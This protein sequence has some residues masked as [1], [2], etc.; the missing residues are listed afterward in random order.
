M[1]QV[2]TK[3]PLNGYPELSYA[4]WNDLAFFTTGLIARSID[5]RELHR[6][7]IKNRSNS[8]TLSSASPLVLLP[9]IEI[10]LSALLP[11]MTSNRDGFESD[12]SAS[13]DSGSHENLEHLSL[14]QHATGN[15]VSGVNKAWADDIVNISFKGI[16]CLAPVDIRNED[17]SQDTQL[18]CISEAVIRTRI[19]ARSALLSNLADGEV[20]Y[21]SRRGQFLLRIERAVSMPMLDTLKSR[22]MAIDRFVKFLEAMDSAGS[23]I[24]TDTVTLRRIA[25][26]YSEFTSRRQQQ[27]EQSHGEDQTRGEESRT[28]KRWRVVLDLSKHDIEIE[29]EKGNPHLRVLDV[30]RQL[31]NCDDGISRLMSWL[32][33]SLPAL[34]AIDEI[35]SLW[36][37]FIAAG[38]GYF[39]FSMKTAVWM[40][41]TY[42]IGTI[43]EHQSL[44]IV[45]VD[46]KMKSRRG[47]AWWHVWRSDTD[48]NSQDDISR[49]LKRVWDS[50]GEGWIG[51]ATGAA[52]R[53]QNGVVAMLLAVDE[54][55]RNFLTDTP[56]D[57]NEVVVLD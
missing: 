12:A 25:F 5:L 34:Q 18:I 53:P 45:S 44:K 23:F 22:I 50:K 46:V 36:V 40:N 29:I 7:K 9:S 54:A 30:M 21:N 33:T 35:A 57:D 3:I 13:E 15:T 4:F 56:A 38:R 55:V 48:A 43:H 16:K 32:P 6:Q 39:D 41:L 31:V 2:R 1:P 42:T 26:Y 28:D 8:K 11:A 27:V 14:I 49:A 51:L 19:S 52:G 20:S 10:A 17:A 24:V 47:E 37:P